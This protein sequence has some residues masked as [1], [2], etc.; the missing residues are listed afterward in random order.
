MWIQCRGQR[1]VCSRLQVGR[2]CLMTSDA[3]TLCSE[4]WEGGQS[5]T[6]RFWKLEIISVPQ[7]RWTRNSHPSAARTAS[8]RCGW[9]SSTG[10][11]GRC[12]LQ[13][14]TGLQH[15]CCETSKKADHGLSIHC[16]HSSLCKLMLN[17]FC[18]KDVFS[19]NIWTFE[20]SEVLRVLSQLGLTCKWCRAL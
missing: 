13:I 20:D 12:K 14:P 8:H 1:G 17:L 10:V 3:A 4:C 7:R 15:S 6:P 18:E 2:A 9:V 16:C 19:R 11:H 5:F